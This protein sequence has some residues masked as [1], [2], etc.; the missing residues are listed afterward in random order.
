MLVLTRGKGEKIEIEAGGERIILTVLGNRGGDR[1]RLGFE[2]SQYVVIHRSEVAEKIR[3]ENSNV[4]KGNGSVEG[5]SEIAGGANPS[6]SVSG[7]ATDSFS[8]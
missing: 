2:A 7:E 1:V 6:N 5:Q 8:T 4:H 3:K